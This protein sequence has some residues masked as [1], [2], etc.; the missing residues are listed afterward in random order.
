MKIK[1]VLLIAKPW[2]GGLADYVFRALQAEF[3][4]GV[5]WLPTYPMDHVQKLLYRKNRKLWR[6]NLLRDIRNAPCEL[7]LFINILP[8]FFDLPHSHK[9]VLWLTDDPR[10]VAPHLH[11]FPTIFLSDPGYLAEFEALLPHSPNVAVLPFACDPELHTQIQPNTNNGMCF[12]GNRDPKRTRHL[13]VLLEQG[14]DIKI[15]GNYFFST[16]LFWKYVKNFRPKI[17]ISEMS[18]IYSNFSSSLNVHAQV[19]RHGTNMRTFECA[20]IGIP[21][22]VEYRP[23]LEDYFLPGEDISVYNNEKDLCENYEEFI[24]DKKLQL[25][26]IQSSRKKVLESHTYKNRIQSIIEQLK[27]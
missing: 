4:S 11:A 20:A 10:S 18:K 6:D 12:L 24:F 15:Y 2:R 26:M 8:E 25:S 23:H 14:K 1:N 13:S 22:L 27:S 17:N 21:Q 16:R 3:G 19:V 5:R 9:N 7:A